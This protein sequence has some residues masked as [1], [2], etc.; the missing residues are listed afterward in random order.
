MKSSSAP[1][2]LLCGI[3]VFVLAALTGPSL[4]HLDYSSLSHTTSELAGQNMPNAWIMRTGFIGYGLAVVAAAALT[5]RSAPDIS[6]ALITF[7]LDR[8]SP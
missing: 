1:R 6:V 7:G 3:G 2:L 8:F 5:F 4:S